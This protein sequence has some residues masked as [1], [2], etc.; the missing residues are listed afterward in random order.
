DSLG[1]LVMEL[2]GWQ[3]VGSATVRNR[4]LLSR[5]GAGY[6]PGQQNQELGRTEP[7]WDRPGIG[8]QLRDR[9]LPDCATGGLMSSATF[10]ELR[11]RHAADLYAAFPRYAARLQWSA[12]QL[13]LEREQRMRVLL[14][15]AKARSPWHRER[16]RDVD[17]ATFTEADL[18]SLPTMSKTDLMDNFD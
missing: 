10:D 3:V 2:G 9:L 18:P 17:V 7:R 1:F 12:A 5:T 4:F 6:H 14:A 11:S 15:T 16:L 8:T 13:Q